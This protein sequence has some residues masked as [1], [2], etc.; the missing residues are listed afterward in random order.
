[1]QSSL[2]P[3]VSL[4]PDNFATPT[5]KFDFAL[6]EEEGIGK[7]ITSLQLERNRNYKI[8]IGQERQGTG[9]EYTFSIQLDGQTKYKNVNPN[10]RQLTKANVHF[11]SVLVESCGASRNVDIQEVSIVNYWKDPQAASSLLGM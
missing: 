6:N 5:L 2:Y 3:A 9:M 11:G 4:S 7:N 8:K 1:M 10:P